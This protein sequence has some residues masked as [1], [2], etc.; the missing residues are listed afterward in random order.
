MFDYIV[1]IP[2]IR[3]GSRQTLDTLINEEAYL[4]AKFL[5]HERETWIPRIASCPAERNKNNSDR[6]CKDNS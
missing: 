4:F 2:R 1:E 3:H 5:R 6:S